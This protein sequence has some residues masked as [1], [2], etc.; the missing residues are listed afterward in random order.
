MRRS[1]HRQRAGGMSR[2]PFTRRTDHSHA[3]HRHAN[4][5]KRTIS[6]SVACLRP[7]RKT[8]LRPGSG[9]GRGSIRGST[10]KDHKAAP[11]RGC[12][13]RTTPTHRSDEGEK[14]SQCLAQH[15]AASWS[16]SITARCSSTG[17]PSHSPRSERPRTRRS[18]T[19]PL[20]ASGS[21]YRATMDLGRPHGSR[22]EPSGRNH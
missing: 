20:S 21:A 15:R 11:A 4:D 7:Q 2:D 5:P 16:A 10:P 13:N 19:S 8:V 1:D 22:I 9:L 17:T 6:H 12:R 3:H 18:G 14:V